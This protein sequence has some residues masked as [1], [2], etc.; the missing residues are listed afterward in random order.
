MHIQMRF[1]DSL[2][3]RDELI[4]VHKKLRK[5]KYEPIS[6]LQF[7]YI[8]QEKGG[9]HKKKKKQNTEQLSYK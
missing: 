1:F 8:V 3:N 5:W 6:E 2:E 9:N 7:F 4:L